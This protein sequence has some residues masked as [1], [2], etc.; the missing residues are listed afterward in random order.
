M[1]ETDASLDEDE[2]I[3]ITTS[4]ANNVWSL[5]FLRAPALDINPIAMNKDVL[6]VK[7]GSVKKS[8]RS[9]PPLPGS[10]HAGQL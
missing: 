9:F 7:K 8:S 5:N 2:L 10:A 1:M 6:E 3:T 4:T